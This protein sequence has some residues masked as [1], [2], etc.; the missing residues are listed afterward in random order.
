MSYAYDSGKEAFLTEVNFD[1]IFWDISDGKKVLFDT[2]CRTNRTGK[3]S[4]TIF[5]DS[6]MYW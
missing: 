6:G 4:D 3:V 1:K 5:G 2:L